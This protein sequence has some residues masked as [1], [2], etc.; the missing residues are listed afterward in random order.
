[1]GTIYKAVY[2]DRT[3][4]SRD[5][6]KITI[7]L[8]LWDDKKQ[9]VRPNMEIDHEKYNYILNQHKSDFLGANKKAVRTNR[10]CFIEFALDYLEKIVLQNH[11]KIRVDICI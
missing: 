1:M 3:P 4:I 6:L 10:D 2:D 7:P 11:L 5:S 8:K 9:K